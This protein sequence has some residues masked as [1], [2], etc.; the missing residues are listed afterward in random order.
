MT[1]LKFSI[2]LSFIEN[3]APLQYQNEIK[4]VNTFIGIYIS[5][6]RKYIIIKYIDVNK[7]IIVRSL[8]NNDKPLNVLSFNNNTYVNLKF[9]VR[10]T[11]ENECCIHFNNDAKLLI[12]RSDSILFTTF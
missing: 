8:F 5:S 2:P 1:K 10:K 11:N 12:T 4:Y 7:N 3:T 6:C 9:Y